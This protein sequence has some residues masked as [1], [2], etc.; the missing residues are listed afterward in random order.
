RMPFEVAYQPRDIPAIM[1]RLADCDVILVDT[2][3]RGPRQIAD[4]SETLDCL[5]TFNPDEIHLV[6]P[7]S[8]NP[9]LS[10]RI[11][12]DARASGV[13]HLLVTKLDEFPEWSAVEHLAVTSGLA[14]RWCTDGQDVPG[15]LARVEDWPTRES[16]RIS[17]LAE[18]V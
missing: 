18:I 2:A 12:R 16:S 13:T 8:L 15:D 3:G 10:A 9:Q 5:R 17:E 1:H 14:M 7:A 11:I 4:A 6:L